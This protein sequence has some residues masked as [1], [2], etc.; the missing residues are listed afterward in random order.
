MERRRFNSPIFIAV[1]LILMFGLIPVYAE[2]PSNEFIFSRAVGQAVSS[3]V[4]SLKLTPGRMRVVREPGIDEL[5]AE[6]FTA[7][8]VKA[9]WVISGVTD[10]FI[11]SEEYESK[12]RISAF[13]FTYEKAGSRG[14]LK[15]P[16]IRRHLRGQI[17]VSLLGPVNFIGYRGFDFS[18]TI[19]YQEANYV[20]SRKYKELNPE[21]FMSGA[22]RYLEPA[23]VI[24]AVGAL[25]FLF[26]NS[27]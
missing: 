18:D 20:A 11:A 17:Y 25:V 27:R 14:I 5:A 22:G 6:A 13:R 8:M 21:L 2:P 3:V 23:V 26:F 24:S 9:G 1:F 10:S 19:R 15:S 7:A 12:I 4:D 16:D